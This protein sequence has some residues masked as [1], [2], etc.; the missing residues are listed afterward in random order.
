MIYF[1]ISRRG[2]EIK[3]KYQ[4]DLGG[5]SSLQA[6]TSDDAWQPWVIFL[7]QEVEQTAQFTTQKEAY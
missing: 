6:I 2:V 1:D 3:E 4:H 7:L 5:R